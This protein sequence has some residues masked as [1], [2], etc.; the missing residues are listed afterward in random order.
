M[1]RTLTCI[2]FLIVSFIG[3]SL[4]FGSIPNNDNSIY[5]VVARGVSQGHIWPLQFEANAFSAK[6]PLFFWVTGAFVRLFGEYESVYRLTNFLSLLSILL[7]VSK[8]MKAS[9]FSKRI[10]ML[11]FLGSPALVEF[12]RSVMLDLPLC[13]LALWAIYFGVSQTSQTSRLWPFFLTCVAGWW[14]KE[15][16]FLPYLLAVFL[17]CWISKEHRGKFLQKETYLGMGLFLLSLLLLFYLL[18][19]VEIS[20]SAQRIHTAKQQTGIQTN[21]QSYF[22][23][24]SQDHPLIWCSPILAVWAIWQ[25]STLIKA[26]GI[27]WIFSAMAICAVE[28]KLPHYLL[29]LF[30]ISLMLTGFLIETISSRI[31]LGCLFVVALTQVFRV[32]ALLWQPDSYFLDPARATKE[33]SKHAI[34]LLP[35]DTYLCVINTYPAGFQLY[36]KRPV[37]GFFTS[38]RAFSMINAVTEFKGMN[39]KVEDSSMESRQES[40]GNLVIGPTEYFLNRSDYF[41]VIRTLDQL[42][43]AEILRIGMSKSKL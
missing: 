2:F 33:L 16:A 25:K 3:A 4:F 9:P 32:Q 22:D 27:A 17:T 1:M 15:I 34:S 14:T 6:P 36:S 39:F 7:L 24:I 41:A 28:L 18:P 12:S 29:P 10:S 20:S 21:W 26:F 19:T 11:L 42:S 37:L 13:A 40:C 5:A 38:E 23:F 30:S 43:V 8:V 31:I 35:Q